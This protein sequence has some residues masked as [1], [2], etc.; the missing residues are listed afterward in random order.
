VRSTYCPG[1]FATAR[2]P[3]SHAVS[4]SGCCGTVSF[5]KLMPALLT[6]MSQGSEVRILSLLRKQD[7]VER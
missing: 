6:R 4:Q 3:N 1:A 2:S 7:S 5:D